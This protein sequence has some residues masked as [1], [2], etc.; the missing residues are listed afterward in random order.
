LKD[1][2]ITNFVTR[3]DP[4][5]HGE[6]N[7]HG[8]PGEIDWKCRSFLN[9]RDYLKRFGLTLLKRLAGYEAFFTN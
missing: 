6:V 5:E 8:K 2:R 7:G 4:Q 1:D 9:V 3:Y